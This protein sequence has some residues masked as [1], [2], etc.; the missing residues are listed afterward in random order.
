MKLGRLLAR[1][2]I[3]GLFIGH[4]TQK[5]FGWF[6]GPGL[7]G[8]SQMMDTLGLRP[9][10]RNALAA[11]ISETAGG[12][13]LAA[14]VL[15]PVAASALIGTMVTAIRTVHYKNGL[16]NSAGGYEFNLALIAATLAIVDGGP[17][18]L[19]LDRALGIHDTGWRWALGSMAAGAAGSTLVIQAGRRHTSPAPAPPSQTPATGTP[20]IQADE[21][22]VT[23][24]AVA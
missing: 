2:V 6:E 12:A 14:G 19:S 21:P 22:S 9:G 4:G 18:P 11:S 8:A 3:G 20:P 15:T 1:G 24:E 16:W 23:P 17:G 13:M 10:R 7:Q 5:L